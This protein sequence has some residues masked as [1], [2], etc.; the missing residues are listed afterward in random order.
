MSFLEILESLPLE[1]P[2]QDDQW[3]KQVNT[4]VKRVGKQELNI[5]DMN[6]SEKSNNENGALEHLNIKK[7]TL[8]LLGE[9]RELNVSGNH[10][11][12]WQGFL[13]ALKYW[14]P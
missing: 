9:S 1:P 8:Y 11:H 4:R 2:V 14:I 3:K 6:S 12:P 13:D 7:Q 5:T 10:W